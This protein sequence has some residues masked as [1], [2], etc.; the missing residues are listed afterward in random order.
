MTQPEFCHQIFLKGAKFN[1]SSKFND[2]LQFF[3]WNS[4]LL[5]QWVSFLIESDLAD[6]FGYQ[7]ICSTMCPV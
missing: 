2:K 6:F 3:F 1:L 4:N 7:K 5:I